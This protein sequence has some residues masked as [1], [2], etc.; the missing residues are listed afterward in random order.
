MLTPVVSWRRMSY[1]SDLHNQ[2]IN[3]MM[4]DEIV[5]LVL[6]D[7]DKNYPMLTFQTKIDPFGQ[8][9]NLE[10]FVRKRE[11]QFPQVVESSQTLFFGNSDS[12]EFIVSHFMKER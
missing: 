7:W 11:F 12:R 3:P 5:V 2:M 9:A 8:I 10:L 4:R 6:S 1:N